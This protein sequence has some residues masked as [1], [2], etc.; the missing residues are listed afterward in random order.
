MIF[1]FSDTDKKF[2]QKAIELAKKGASKGDIPVGAVVVK[3]DEIIGKGYNMKFLTGD[4]TDHAEMIALKEASNSIGDWR[5]TECTLYSTAEPCI[6]CSG[7]ILHYRIKRVIFGVTEPKFGGVIT[8]VKLFDIDSLN[9]KVDYQYG[10][11]QEE[12]SLMMKEF[13]RELRA[14]NKEK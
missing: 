7:A 6:M 8:K 5:L 1:D 13:F 14:K 4:P 11:F 10:L 3:D 9:H 12:V 2:M